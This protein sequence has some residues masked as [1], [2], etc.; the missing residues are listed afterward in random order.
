MVKIF[1]CYKRGMELGLEKEC[2]FSPSYQTTVSQTQSSSTASF[3][4]C[5]FAV[6]KLCLKTKENGSQILH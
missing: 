4:L 5:V 2:F 3:R 1:V 6:E